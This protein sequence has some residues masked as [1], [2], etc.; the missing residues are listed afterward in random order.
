MNLIN[1]MLLFHGPLEYNSRILEK[2]RGEIQNQFE[3]PTSDC[4]IIRVHVAE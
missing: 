2:L 1:V 4:Y 3:L